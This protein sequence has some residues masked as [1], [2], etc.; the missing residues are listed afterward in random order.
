[1]RSDFLKDISETSFDLIVVGGGITGAGISLDAASRGIKTLLIEKNDFASGT[2][3]KSTKLIHGGLRYLKQFDFALVRESGRER[4]VAHKLAR[5]LVR[6]IKMLLPITEGGSHGK[7]MSS[8]GLKIYDIL[9]RVR[10]VD[11]RKM[12]SKAHVMDILPQFDPRKLIAGGYYVEYLSNDARLTLQIVKRAKDHGAYCLNYAELISFIKENEKITG[13]KFLDKENNQEVIAKCKC[14]VSATGPWVDVL[15]K[16]D[17]IDAQEKLLLSKGVHVVYPFE[18]LPLSSAVYFD[19]HEGRMI[20][21]IPFAGK[22]YV[23]TTDTVFQKDK[24]DI[25]VS[26]EEAEYL[27]KSCNHVFP[28]SHL[29]VSDINSSWAGLRPLIKAEGKGP[30]ELSRKDEIFISKSGLISIAG[31]KLTGYRKMAQRVLRKVRLQ[32]GD[33]YGKSKTRRIFLYAEPFKS[34]KAYKNALHQL[35]NECRTR[36]I[37]LHYVELLMQNYGKKAISIVQDSDNYDLMPVQSLAL[38]ELDYCLHNEMVQSICD[39]MIRRSNRIYFDM[40]N[41]KAVSQ[42]C[43]EH[44][45][46]KLN[47]SQE[48]RDHEAQKLARE[49]ERATIFK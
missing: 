43:L 48:K 6:P 38:A 44:L 4:A 26:L 18:K 23:G 5:N 11:R 10:P 41:V 17:K 39:F 47:W 34:E 2:S 27:T 7:N 13:V 16:Q 25:K 46:N 12:L 33:R 15:R 9:A 21:A 24:D 40:P 22:T 49:I 28:E 36:H 37:P 14:V 35:E 19:N 3:S 1:M 42:V 45:S 30:S 20:F 32:I 8:L 29:K 31:G